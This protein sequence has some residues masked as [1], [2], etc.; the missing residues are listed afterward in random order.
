MQRT[1]VLDKNRKPLMPCHP[2]RARMLIKR[3]KARVY[4]LQPFTIL[5]TEREGGATQL[6]EQKFDPGSRRTG[7]ALVATFKKRGRTTV[8]GAHL[9]H[10]GQQI[11]KA[12]DKRRAIRRFRRSRHCRYRKP[13]FSNRRR[14]PGW[15]PPS[16]QSRV[17]NVTTWASKLL[18]LAPCKAIAVETSRFDTQ[19]MQNPEI[20]GIEYQQGELFGYELREYLLEKWARRC[21]Y[22]GAKGV[23]LQIFRLNTSSLKAEAGVTVLAI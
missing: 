13:R 4:R 21:A 9:K 14:L 2:A 6:I 18:R 17:E 7:I 20:R 23:P 8:F 12:L 11:K 1:F 15:L 10:R 22:C 5:L 19:K 3:G 16:L